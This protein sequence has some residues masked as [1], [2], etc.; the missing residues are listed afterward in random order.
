VVRCLTVA[1][2][3]TW[4]AAWPGNIGCDIAQNTCEPCADAQPPFYVGSPGAARRRKMP[5]LY[6]DR[7]SM[8]P[9]RNLDVA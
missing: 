2:Q 9:R 3:T 4:E 6:Y 7:S 5:E 1:R 8:A